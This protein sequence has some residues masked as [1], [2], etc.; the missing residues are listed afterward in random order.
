MNEPVVRVDEALVLGGGGSRAGFEIGALSYLYDV[1]KIRPGIMAGSS[2]GAIIAAVLAQGRDPAEQREALRVLEG[3]WR[4]ASGPADMF[5]DSQWLA[6]LRRISPEWQEVLRRRRRPYG[7]GTHARRHT[8]S[9]I[10]VPEPLVDGASRTV[11]VLLA[12]RALG[13]TGRGLERLLGTADHT[14]ALFR[15]GPLAE[16]LRGADVFQPARVEQSGVRLRIAVVGLESGEL[17]YVTESGSLVGRDDEPL[18]GRH[19]VSLS[20]AVLASCAIPGIF[21]PVV[22]AGEHY[23]DGGVREVLPVEVVL[24]SLHAERCYAITAS[25]SAPRARVGSQDTV[26]SILNRTVTGLMWDE[27][28]RDEIEAVRQHPGLTLI[29]PDLDVHDGFT[30]DPGLIS[31]AID[32]GYM[33]AADVVGGLDA[34]QQDLTRQIVM[35]R[36]SMVLLD[37]DGPE[38]TIV[39][40][41]LGLSEPLRSGAYTDVESAQRRLRDLVSRKPEGA[42]PPGASSWAIGRAGRS[43]TAVLADG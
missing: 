29:S 13:R 2:A 26:L 17:R 7:S 1:V 41:P 40:R 42:L 24:R 19:R 14:T 20:D 27:L 16:D 8:G 30:V 22:L 12:L 38:P 43:S 34:R 15:P 39:D 10:E 4:R 6:D 32:Y 18:P 31:L 21:A 25:A 37:R 11:E 33:R 35:L 5:T 9:A 36:R 3:V 23:V 28:L